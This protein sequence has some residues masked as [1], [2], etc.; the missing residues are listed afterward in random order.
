MDPLFSNKC[1]YTKEV[2]REALFGYNKRKSTVSIV[3][4]S[5][6]ILLT[7]YQI[8]FYAGTSDIF[9]ALFL[10]GLSVL[11]YVILPIFQANLSYKRTIE[12]HHEPITALTVFFDDHFVSTAQP[13]NA[14]ITVKYDQVKRV[15]STKQLYLLVIR[16]QLFYIIDKNGF[17]KI[18]MLEF[19]K[20]LREKAPKAK[21]QL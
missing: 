5:I 14:T 2:F 3:V 19:E 7:I 1:T 17:D 15:I 21:F 8:I 9:L 20:F 10:L 6:V 16:L 18:N 13:S 4:L 11:T 12:L